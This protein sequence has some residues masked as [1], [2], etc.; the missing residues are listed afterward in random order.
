ML[1]RWDYLCFL[2]LTTNGTASRARAAKPA[3]Q[4]PEPPCPVLPPGT[5][6][7]G[8]VGVSGETGAAS[9]IV[10]INIL[11]VL[12]AE[13]AALTVKELASAAVGVPLMTSAELSVNPSGREPLASVQVISESPVAARVAE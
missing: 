3:L 10:S 2:L 8:E 9:V 11:V 1:L 4:P 6:V 5:G 13:F 7:S 12:P